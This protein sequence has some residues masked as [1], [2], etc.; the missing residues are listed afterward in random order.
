MKLMNTLLAATGSLL[1]LGS[2]KYG[3]A[4]KAPEKNRTPAEVKARKKAYR[5]RKAAKAARRRNRK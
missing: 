4:V 1:G 3:L 5:K 2:S